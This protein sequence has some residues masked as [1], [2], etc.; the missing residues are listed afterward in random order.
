MVPKNFSLV[1]NECVNAIRV[2]SAEMV[3]KANS[4]HPGAPMGLAPLA[5]VLFSRHLKCHGEDPNWIGRDRFV[6]SNGHACAL[7]YSMLHLLGYADCSTE[8]LESFRQLGSTTPGHPESHVTR[9]IEVTTGPLGQG[10]ANA[11]GLAIAQ[12]NLNSFFSTSSPSS[13]ID[14]ALE[15]KN[16][17]FSSKSDLKNI[18]EPFSG[19]TFNNDD[20]LLSNKKSFVTGVLD[21]SFVYSIVGDGCLMEGVCAEALSLAGH[22]RLGNLIVFWDDNKISIDGSTDLAFTENVMQRLESYGFHTLHIANGDTDLEGISAAIESAKKILD[23]PSFIRITTTIGFGSINAGKEKVHGAPLGAEDI[24]RV[25]TLFNYNANGR[26]ELPKS[27]SE[28]YENVRACKRRV[29]DHWVTTLWPAFE[30]QNPNAVTDFNRR[31]SG[32]LPSPI[33]AALPRYT[34]EDKPFASRKAS[35]NVLNAIAPLLSELIGG[36]AD[37]SHSNLVRWKGAVDFQFLGDKSEQTNILSHSGRYIRFGVRE[38]AMFAICNGISAYLPGNVFLPFASTFLNFI[39]YGLGAVRLSCISGHRVLYIMTHD[40]IGLGEDGPTH[41]PVETMAALRAMPNLL[42]IRPADANEVSGAYW[43]ALNHR[44][45]PSVICL[46]R[47]EL[48]NIINSSLDQVSRGAYVIYESA[49]AGTEKKPNLVLVSTGSEVSICIDVAKKLEGEKNLC[50]RV[51]SM[52]SWELFEKL[53]ISERRSL[54]NNYTVPIVSVEAAS[55]FG[56]SRYSHMALGVNDFGLSA[57]FKQV[58]SHFGLTVDKVSI[59][60]LEAIEKFS[61][62]VPDLSLMW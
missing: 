14:C 30:L 56:W 28:F 59:R 5:H 18:Q 29:Y 9:G 55:T 47:Q 54:F 35:E 22:L 43:A 48:P 45:G 46:S 7:L 51:L 11:V 17:P 2:L 39:S 4:G 24:A 10:I 53:E 52:P 36:S 42:V 41:Q 1:D 33:Y 34:A 37:L 16:S 19:S 15:S 44:T 32:K 12:T 49:G 60:A 6:L 25:R 58:Y 23:R 31:I 21:D 26:F 57:P 62:N 61:S 3:Q 20:A 40:S 13:Q 8:Q 50:I 38:H 27:V